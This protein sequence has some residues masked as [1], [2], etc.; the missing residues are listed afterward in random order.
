MQSE[1]ENFV[2]NDSNAMHKALK[3]MAGFEPMIFYSIDTCGATEFFVL[4]AVQFNFGNALERY[5]LR[6]IVA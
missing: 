2:T 5:F 4:S 1:N 3:T 6:G